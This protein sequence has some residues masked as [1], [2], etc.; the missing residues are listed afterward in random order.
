MDMESLT[1]FELEVLENLPVEPLGMSLSELADGLLDDYSPAG[2]GKVLRALD[3]ILVATG[4][5]YVCTGDDSLGGFGRMYGIP[6]RMM[7]AVRQF[8]ADR[9]EKQLENV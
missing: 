8:F 1:E 4:A 3:R 6:Q 9:A 2:K 5:L 7:P